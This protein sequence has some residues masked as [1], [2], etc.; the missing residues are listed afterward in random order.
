VI[1]YG[2]EVGPHDE[3]TIL[4]EKVTLS[5]GRFNDS[6]ARPVRGRTGSVS[7]HR[8]ESPDFPSSAP[9]EP[10]QPV[11]PGWETVVRGG[12]VDRKRPP[13][14]RALS[15]NRRIASVGGLFTLAAV[16]CLAALSARHRSARGAV[17]RA[18]V[19]V[20]LV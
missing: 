18:C 17:G 13:V 3:P 5:C 14:E 7:A 1:E 15:T 11:P 10:F 19:Q 2:S 4:T 6:V 9:E 16:T 12:R 20:P 8:G